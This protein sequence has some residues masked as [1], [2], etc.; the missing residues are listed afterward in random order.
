[1]RC[2]HRGNFPAIYNNVKGDD[3]AG[4]A[5]VLKQAQA[6]GIEIQKRGPKIVDVLRRSLSCD[7]PD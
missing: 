4:Y 6:C 2:L 7:R 3:Y 1:M 5:V